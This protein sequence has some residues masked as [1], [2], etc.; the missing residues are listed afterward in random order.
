MPPRK[1]RDPHEDPRATPA[2]R[3]Q[4]S[5]FLRP[6]GVISSVCGGKP[7]RAVQAG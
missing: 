4:K 1:G 3:L 5:R 7:C 2:N 6:A